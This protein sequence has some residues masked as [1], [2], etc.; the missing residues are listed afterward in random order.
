MARSDSG[1]RGVDAEGTMDPRRLRIGL[2]VC[3]AMLLALTG[4]L[5]FVQ[6]LDPEAVAQE[7]AT[8]RTRTELIPPT[9]GDILDS[10][11]R[12]FATS[13]IRYDLV[14]DQKWYKE[15]FDRR[16]PDTGERESARMDDAIDALSGLVGL[17]VQTLR[18]SLV[19]ADPES[20]KRYS[21][22]AK[23]VTPE[24]KEAVMDLG[25]P[26]LLAER[27]NDRQY[28]NGSVAGTLLGFLSAATTNDAGQN[29]GAEGLELTQNDL[30]AGTSGERKYE[31]GADGVRI[32]TAPSTTTPAVDGKDVQLTINEDVQWAAQEAVMAKQ[33]Q[34]DPDWV[35]AVVLELETGKIRAIADSRSVD[36]ND[37][38]AVDAQ[39]R[40]STALTQAF[41]PGS[42]GKL[43]TFA[44]AIEEG[45]VDPEEAFTIPNSYTTQN[46]TIHDSL[47]HATYPMTAAGIF[48]RSYNTGTVMI[49]ERLSNQQR[50]DYFTKFGIGEGINMGGLP[51]AEGIFVE[52]SAWD[53]RQQFTTMFGQGYTQT[54]LHTAQMFQG[55]AN[56]GQMIEPS[57]IEAYIDPDG[58]RHEPEPHAP[59]RVVSKK[60]SDVMLRMM[61]TVVTDGTAQGAAIDG[62]RVGGKTGTGQAANPD[63]GGYDGHTSSFAG[64]A[65]LDDPQFVVVVTMHR[66][67]GNW[68]DWHVTD[69]FK[70]IMEA[71][72]N[73]YDVPPS[74][75]EPNPY[76]AFVGDQQKY[77]WE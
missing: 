39:Y 69:T 48:A 26:G 12:A 66:P 9:R 24:T 28:P 7:A 4:R 63:G 58:T 22:V 50:Y 21:V 59:E 53:R 17:D 67:Q 3:L 42:T 35:S 19:P 60:T 61:E 77:G 71:T 18:E 5:F 75:S 30:L 6:G 74:D 47:K 56:G 33:E 40:T 15:E 52:P 1:T 70:T 2:A 44:A 43:A 72:L 54:V 62:Y 27:T 51:V 31:V 68:R 20:P 57:L 32:P 38:A 49:G 45:V 37:P 16:N 65:P 46:E 41:E 10:E 29:T 8:S 14:T 73:T 64:V 76:K 11:G 34:F 36:P 55:I 13:V 25:I 23:G